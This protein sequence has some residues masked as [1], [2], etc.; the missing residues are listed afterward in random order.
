MRPLSRPLRNTRFVLQP[1]CPVRAG[2]SCQL[3]SWAPNLGCSHVLAA[4][5]TPQPLAKVRAGPG[6]AEIRA[7]AVCRDR[8]GTLPLSPAPLSPKNRLGFSSFASGAQPG[9]PSALATMPSP[10]L[11]WG[12]G[13]G[14]DHHPG[15]GDQPPPSALLGRALVLAGYVWVCMCQTVNEFDQPAPTTASRASSFQG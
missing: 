5:A 7:L 2:G 4:R 15:L 1:P 8:T 13:R 9:C 12:G 10:C 11:A 6:P 14:R 3:A